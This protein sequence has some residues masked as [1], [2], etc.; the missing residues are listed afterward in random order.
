MEIATFLSHMSVTVTICDSIPDQE[1]EM[2]VSMK[3]SIVEPLVSKPKPLRD[4]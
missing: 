3:T 1:M 2:D 4:S